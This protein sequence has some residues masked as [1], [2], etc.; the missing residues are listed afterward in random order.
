LKKAPTNDNTPEIIIRH[1]HR[2][3]LMMRATRAGLEVYVPLWL[4][5]D[6]PQVRRF[7]QD[8]LRKLADKVPPTP[9]PQTSPAEL[10]ALVHAW[11]AR[12][13]VEPGRITLRPM[14]RKWGS[15]S[16]RNNITLNTALTW[17]PRHLAEYVILHEL[18]HLKA[19]NHGPEFKKLLSQ[20]MADWQARD[21]ELDQY[22][23]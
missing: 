16:G 18:A 2:R 17:L 3:S 12:L 23:P 13:E 4:R 9:P 22:H 11:A 19:F 21:R 15:C 10:R 20:H 7:I 6:S 5:K 8:G 1:Q 14:Q